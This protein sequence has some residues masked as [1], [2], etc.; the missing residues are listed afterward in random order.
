M[1]EVEP[2]TNPT[3][4]AEKVY[5]TLTGYGVERGYNNITINYFN[6][7]VKRLYSFDNSTWYDYQDKAIKLDYGTTVYAKGIN[8]YGVVTNTVSLTSTVP[9]DTLGPNAYDGNDSTC[10]RVSR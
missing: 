2:Y 3:I 7:G 5:P 1:Y 6:T 10:T 8:K 9:S 4:N